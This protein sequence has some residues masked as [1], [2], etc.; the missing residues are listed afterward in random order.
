M[1]MVHAGG[2]IVTEQDVLAVDVPPPSNRHYAVPHSYL[3]GTVRDVFGSMFPE[4][5][6]VKEQYALGKYDRNT[7]V[8]GQMFGLF[9]YDTGDPRFGMAIGF[10][11]SYD[12]SLAA[13][14]VGGANPFVCDNLCFSG[15]SFAIH[16]KNTMNAIHELYHMVLDNAYSMLDDYRGMVKGF[17]VLETIEVSQEEGYETLGVMFGNEVI[18]PRQYITAVEAW[19]NPPQEDWAPRN[20]LS[21]YN[22]VTE[23]TKKPNVVDVVGDLS[24]PHKFFKERFHVEYLSS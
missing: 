15:D 24:R 13:G 17:E 4:F 19:R 20:A 10:R 5:K 1:F 11:N 2:R 22:A 6:L 18:K 9:T 7:K 14:V 23:G 16:R 3:I 12:K 21:L 8:P